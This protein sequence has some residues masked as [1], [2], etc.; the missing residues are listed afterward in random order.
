VKTSA[1]CRFLLVLLAL[2]ASLAAQPEP[3]PVPRTEPPSPSLRARFGIDAVR[4]WLRAEPT[5]LRQRA[6]ERLGTL[7]SNAA[8][9]LL[10]TALGNGGEARDAR[11]RLVVVRALAPH[12]HQEGAVVA[13]VRALGSSSRGDEPKDALVER[14]A[15]LALARSKNPRAARA[16][17]QALRQPGRVAAIARLALRAYP[18]RDL[19]ALLTAPGVPTSELLELLGELANPS[20]RSFLATPLMRW[21]SRG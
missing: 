5:L 17:F 20:A 18:P 12:T 15:A 14:T 7:G 19:D 1:A 4:P 3:E 16:L 11:E 8:I 13:L 9:E 21:R 2:P 10:A 6:F